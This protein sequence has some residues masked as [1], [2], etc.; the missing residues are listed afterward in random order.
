MSHIAVPVSLSR[1]PGSGY[2]VTP[3]LQYAGSIAAYTTLQD[4]YNLML[5]ISAYFILI[6]EGIA[7]LR[8]ELRRIVRILGLPSALVASVER[9]ACRLLSA[10]V[11]AEFTLVDST[12]GA[13]PSVFSRLGTSALGTELTGSCCT[14]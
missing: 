4:S 9:C 3:D 13:C 10:A 11:L 1:S 8:A 2:A 7:A 12:A 6:A 5:Y 14:T